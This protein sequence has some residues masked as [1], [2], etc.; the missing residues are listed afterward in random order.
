MPQ[1]LLGLDNGGTAIKCGLYTPAGNEVAVAATALEMRTPQAGFTERDTEAIWT[2]NC[3][4]I[5][6][7]LQ[8]TGVRGSDIAAVSVTGYGNGINLVDSSGGAVYPSIVSTDTRANNYIEQWNTDGTADLVEKET[9][10]RIYAAQPPALLCWFRDNC[11]H[12]LQKARWALSIKDFV[13]FRL[14]GEVYAELTDLSGTCLMNIRERR[15]SDAVIKAL[16]IEAYR[17][18]LPDRVLPPAGLAGYV[19][20]EAAEA[21]GLAKGTPVAAGL[22]DIDACCV[23]NGIKDEHTLCL[24]TGTWSINEYITPNINDGIGMF[25]TTNAYLPAHYLISDSSPTSVSNYDWYLRTIMRYRYQIDFGP[26]LFQKCDEVL[27][28]R[29]PEDNETIFVPY[30]FA[31]GSYTKDRGAFLNLAAWNDAESMLQA[32]CEGVI[33]SSAHH[34]QRL[35]ARRRPFE[36]ARLSGAVSKVAAWAQMMADT[37]RIPLEV[38]NIKEHGARGAAICAGICAG[39]WRDFTD[40]AT[41]LEDEVIVYTPDR[42]RAPAYAEKLRAYI[43]AVAALDAFHKAL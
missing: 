28:A 23:S 21:T 2:A 18:L 37:L 14:T 10:Q 13:R 34:V 43:N 29:G 11:P 15:Y 36:K 26:A 40:A 33:F 17:H 39:L 41:R 42:A 31:S 3:S 5:R 30:L 16:G 24:V 12:V 8:K 6:A 35:L 9:N 7:V 4:V 22:F 32:V 25:S 19:T 20:A 1:Y 27:G 38:L